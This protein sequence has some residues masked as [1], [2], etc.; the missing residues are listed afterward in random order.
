MLSAG[1]AALAAACDVSGASPFGATSE[2]LRTLAIVGVAI[3]FVLTLWREVA[4]VLE[5]KPNVRF[6][7]YSPVNNHPVF[8]GQWDS[9]GKPVGEMRPA[10]FRRVAFTNDATDPSGDASIAKY[11]SAE[12]IISDMTA[13][14]VDR[15]TGRW[16]NLSE[17]RDPAHK[18]IAD[19]IDLPPNGQEAILDLIMRFVGTTTAIGWDNSLASGTGRRPELRDAEYEIEVMLR[20]ANMK[21]KSFYFSVTN[22]P[23]VFDVELVSNPSKP[24]G[25]PA[26]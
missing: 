13:T 6:R 2:Q 23:D 15:Y 21:K 25:H 8:F 3:F 19:R 1:L 5:P 22:T 16:A 17:A 11:L 18:W 10:D 7:C 24:L 26:T 4:L 14:Q 20:A 12:V 9:E